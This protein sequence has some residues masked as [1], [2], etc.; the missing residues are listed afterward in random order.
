MRL[1]RLRPIRRGRRLQSKDG[2]EVSPGPSRYT[3]EAGTHLEGP[4][5]VPGEGG[6]EWSFNVQADR[7]GELWRDCVF[8]K[9]NT[10]N[11]GGQ[12]GEES[13]CWQPWPVSGSE[14][15]L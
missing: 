7:W 1:Q 6:L 15:S 8:W 14:G 2:L 9:L 10:G 4:Q 13:R 11:G 3:E 5:K 12:A